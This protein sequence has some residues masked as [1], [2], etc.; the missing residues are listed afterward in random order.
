MGIND[1]PVMIN[2]C[3][4][5]TIHTVSHE[6]DYL[7][8]GYD[9]GTFSCLEGSPGYDGERG[10]ITEYGEFNWMNFREDK[11]RRFFGD[12]EYEAAR[13]AEEKRREEYKKM[14]EEREYTEFLRLKQKFESK[15]EEDTV[16]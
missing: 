5:K 15:A 1:D 12:D 13:Q 8:I 3:V 11:M 9:D 2:N 10:E 7:F 14:R 4:G 6:E 16:S